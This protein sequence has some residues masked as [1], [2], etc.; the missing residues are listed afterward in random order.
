MAVFQI[1]KNN[2]VHILSLI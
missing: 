1:V 2:E